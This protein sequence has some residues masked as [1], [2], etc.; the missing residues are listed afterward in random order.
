M[1]RIEKVAPDLWRIVLAEPDLIN[2]YV[3]GD[4]LFD[5]GGRMGERKLLEALESI[6]LSA[7]ALTHGHFDHQGSSHTVCEKFQIPLMCGA[8]DGLAMESGDFGRLMPQRWR[9]LAR[10]MSRLNGSVHPVDRVL[11]EGDEIGGFKVIE[12]PGHTPGHLS[13]FR[14]QDRVLIV[15]DVLFHRSPVTLLKGLREPF[16]IATFNPATNRSSARKLAALQPRVICF[17]HGEPLRDGD[18]FCRFVDTL[19]RD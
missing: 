15:G 8:E 2:V 10:L 13:F 19:R 9:F 16:R 7:H 4:V 11:V 3:A 6:K 18:E 5:S 1:V 14:E 12:T 17:G